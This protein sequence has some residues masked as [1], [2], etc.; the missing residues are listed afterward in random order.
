MK[1]LLTAWFCASIAAGV[2]L[3]FPAQQIAC[4]VER[5]ALLS[6]ASVIIGGLSVVGMGVGVVWAKHIA[7]KWRIDDE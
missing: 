1:T 5:W 6:L 7:D 4:H 3:Y 2:V